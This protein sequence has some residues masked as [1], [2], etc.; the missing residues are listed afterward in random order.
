MLDDVAWDCELAQEEVFGPVLVRRS[1]CDGYDDAM[2]ISNSV[3]YGMSGTIF[4]RDMAR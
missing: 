1:T 2:R 4:T 3:R